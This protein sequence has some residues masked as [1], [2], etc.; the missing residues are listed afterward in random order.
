LYLSREDSERS[1]EYYSLNVDY[2]H[3]FTRQGHELSGQAIYNG[4][5]GDENAVNELRDMNNIITS[6]QRSM[7]KGPSNEVRLKIDYILPLREKDRFEAGYQ[8]RL[9][10]SEDTNERCDYN[11]EPGDYDF[12]PEFSYTTDY[13]RNIHSVYTL[14][15][16]EIGP[17]G[18]QA[19]MRGEYTDRHI[20]LMG[21][22]ERFTLDRRDYFPTAHLSYKLPAG[23]QLM[24]N[25]TRRI[26][27][28]RGWHL[29]PFRTW[30]DAYNVR[31]WNPDLK[32]EYIDSY[33]FGYQVYMG[34]NLLSAES[35]YRKTNNKVER[36]RTVFLED[37]YTVEDNVTLHSIRNVGV[38]YAMGTEFM[39][40]LNLFP[41]WNV[42]LM[43][44]IYEYE[45]KRTLGDESFSRDSFNWDARINHT[46][47]VRK[48]TRLQINGMYN[49]KS[50]SAQ[51]SRAGF[52][53]TNLAIRQ[54]LMGKNLSATLQVRDLFQT[55]KHES[56]SEGVDFYRYSH[57]TR[58][59]P[60]FMLNISYNI[61]NFKPERERELEEFEGEEDF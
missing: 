32:L 38:D 15:A 50:V 61:N 20:T 6:G 26:E 35:Y 30:T 56:V 48:S 1:G 12:R 34:K 53:M 33:E 37:G 54:D 17:F 8:S 10:T 4:R 59:A 5:D 47:T 25:Y 58:K 42:N 16:G 36:V 40:N 2:R 51:G 3:R 23:Q 45:I 24:A 29:E 28:P 18:H 9:H 43:S 21:E 31:E 11:P 57:F 39:F 27:R 60:L 55:A 52:F 7:E 44:N 46:V 49:S 14:Y 13:D 19:G 41:W 22:D